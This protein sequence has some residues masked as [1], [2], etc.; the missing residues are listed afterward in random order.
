MR[1]KN[2]ILLVLKTRL[3]RAEERE[4]VQTEGGK[5]RLKKIRI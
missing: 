4:S 2:K 3:E 5:K 1:S